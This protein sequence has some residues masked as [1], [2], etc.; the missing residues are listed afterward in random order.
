MDAKLCMKCKEN[1]AKIVIRTNDPFCWDC[2]LTYIVHKFRAIIGKSKL[3]R[4]AEPVLLAYSGGSSSSALLHLVHDGMEKSKFKKLRFKA[5]VVYIDEGATLGWSHEKRQEVVG[6]VADF[7]RSFSF[8]YYITSLEQVFK[9]SAHS[10]ETDVSA[11]PT[12]MKNCSQKLHWDENSEEKLLK[13]LSD[14]KNLTFKEQLVHHLRTELLIAVAQMTGN[15]KVMVGTNGNRLAVQMLSDIAQGRGAHV[16]MNTAFCDGRNEDVSIVRPLKDYTSKEVALYNAYNSVDS[17]TNTSITTMTTSQSSIERLTEKF[18]TGLHAEYPATVCNITR[19]A[20]K[21]DSQLGH[22]TESRCAL[23]KACL[24]TSVDNAS[25]LNSVR[26]SHVLSKG[27]SFT[28]Q[29]GF[30]NADNSDDAISDRFCYG[31]QAIVSHLKSADGLPRHMT[32][33]EKQQNLRSLQKESIQ[34][35]LLE[36]EH[37]NCKDES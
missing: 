19:T 18:V 33:N 27:S 1:E 36:D 5:E 9:L 31:C 3:I 7:C 4:D 12:V 17:V 15:S 30:I 35:F 26:L 29:N 37:D 11:V 20:E 32:K 25:A 22:T 14:C 23:C 28:Q 10:E 13:L 16:A 8:T 6:R 21:L 2:F 24:D 34:E